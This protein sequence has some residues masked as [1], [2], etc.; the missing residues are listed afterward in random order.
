MLS[1]SLLYAARK[2]KT[3]LG[4]WVM[5]RPYLILNDTTMALLR[6]LIEEKDPDHMHTRLLQQELLHEIWLLWTFPDLQPVRHLEWHVV[7]NT[8]LMMMSEMLFISPYEYSRNNRRFMHGYDAK[9][10]IEQLEIAYKD[11]RAVAEFTC[12]KDQS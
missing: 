2:Q 6:C 8:N 4:K 7:F 5:T 9:C 1:K 12:V 11:A 3:I 10:F